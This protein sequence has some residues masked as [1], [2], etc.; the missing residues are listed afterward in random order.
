[1]TC[2]GNALT[3]G[4]ECHGYIVRKIIP[5]KEIHGVVYEFEHLATGARHLHVAVEDQE[6]CFAVGFKTI[7][8]DSTGVAHILEHTILC[9]SKKYPVRDPF[10]S[11]IRRSLNSFMNAFTASDWT[12]YPFASP[13]RKDFYNL[14]DVY[15]DAV[16]FPVLSELSFKQEGHRLDTAGGGD[17]DNKVLSY[18][19]VV[20]NE[21][22]G[23][24]SSPD[25][26][27]SHALLEHLYPDTTYHFN[28]GGDP[29]VIPSLSHEQLVA[30]HRRHYHPSN[31]FFYTYGDIP[32]ADHLEYISR[33]VLDGV[34]RIDP[35]TEVPSQ[36]RW[37]APRQ[38]ACA[39]AISEDEED[40]DRK[41]QVC[42]AWL[43]SDIR[44]SFTVLALL[45]LEEVLLG[46]PASPLYKALIDSGMGSSLSD[47]TGFSADIRD[48]MFA[49]GLKDV[50]KEDAPAVEALIIKT[51]AGLADNGI[52][53][54]LVDAAV[55][56]I[57]FHRKEITN[58]PYPYGLKLFLS[59]AS[60]W[61]HGAPPEEMINI[62]PDIKRLYDEMAAGP[63]LENMIRT[64][65]LDNPHRVTL[66]LSPDTE[67]AER[68]NRQV[69]ETLEKTRQALSEAD[70]KKIEE[71]NA[72][73]LRLQEA[74]EDLSVLPTLELSD[75]P[76]E[77]ARIREQAGPPSVVCF[78][79]PTSG[80]FYFSA[81]AGTAELP[82]D[83]TLL[84]PF[85]CAALPRM[86][87]KKRDYLEVARFI[88]RYTG[89][90]GL[91]AQSHT[92]YTPAGECVAYVS[93]TGKCLERNQE[94]L[95]EIIRE[96]FCE[97]D[98]SNLERLRQ[99]LM[100]YRASLESA[101]VHN[102]HR[103]AMSLASRNFSPASAL[104][105][106]WYGVRQLQYIKA[107][108][109]DLN[110]TALAAI[111][112][113]LRRAAVALLRQGNLRTGLTGDDP[114][115]GPAVS[116]AESLAA[117]LPEAA[118]SD[119]FAPPVI[120]PPA[121]IPLE[122]WSTA[123]AVSFVASVFNTIRLGHPDAP[124]LA[125]IARLLKSSFLHREI[126]EKGGA[127]GGYA[128]Y[129]SEDGQFCFASYR[130][131][132]IV[133]T[134]EVYR[135]A[136]AFIQ[137]DN[138]SDEEIKESILQVCSDIDRPLTPAEKGLRAFQRKLMALSDDQRQS[139]KEGVLA[140]TKARV[141]AAAR[142]CFPGDT[143][144]YGI[145]VI[146]DKDKLEAANHELVPPL[147]LNKI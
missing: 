111:A 55:H 113:D 135:R 145:A 144:Q 127:Y 75:I 130:D 76:P 36:P 124:A 85:F 83:L 11:M 38:A 107:I 109:A 63:F 18:Q 19:G 137:E 74:E 88:D 29:G 89:G 133:N 57:E 68:E 99:L 69:A 65:F 81:A 126:R 22:K 6:N 138:F 5:F 48:T 21:M 4:R 98:F 100:E 136:A 91:S 140:V 42:V 3:V 66:T 116:F 77:V 49:C 80:I 95:F 82:E 106:Q 33:R 35:G 84:A 97:F 14:M 104:S 20:Y 16:F 24:M 34:G 64:C 37:Q 51:L 86:G 139:F 119:A 72:L 121:D 134:L 28:S 87:T 120:A 103:L 110:E 102:G 61:F 129:N 71:D 41:H 50:K 92:R 9:G 15:L 52:D 17:D 96:L 59:L 114:M 12:M 46:N 13:N 27:L 2:R 62:D 67:L 40:I 54:D 146:S 47:G 73:L 147:A 117:A 1:M 43:T 128:L 53:R 32:A 44:D 56:Q 123:T 31:A 105:E 60:G 26:V 25:Q 79:Q 7:P 23:A 45:V 142:A 143:R 94:R 141:V 8:R 39:Y 118:G 108:T 132:H 115:L 122:G 70:M 58:S 131:P 112:T 30:F 101:V 10:F 93:F 125:V 90:I 78:P